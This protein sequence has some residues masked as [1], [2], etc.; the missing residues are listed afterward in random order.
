MHLSETEELPAEQKLAIAHCAPAI[1]GRLAAFFGLDRRLGRIVANA[2]EP[3]LAQMRLAWWRDQLAQ[4][5]E[6]RPGG[7][8]VLDAIGV[9]WVDPAPLIAL[10]DAWEVLVTHEELAPATIQDFAEGRALPLGH[11]DAGAG[12]ALRRRLQ[13]AGRRW[14]LADAAAHTSSNEERLQIVAAGLA[15]DGAKN[16]LP[17]HV[18]GMMI[19]EALAIRA[20]RRGGYPLMEGRGAALVALRVGL[21]GR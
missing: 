13:S 11:L 2:G 5:P 1:R 20:L 19:L 8:A 6:Q 16:G 18:R 7:D 12:E 14:A 10:V 9:E 15:E 3:M 4:P 17:R 21:L